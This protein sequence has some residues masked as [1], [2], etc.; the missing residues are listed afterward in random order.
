M[1]RMENEQ[2]FASLSMS[3]IDDGE[4]AI[5]YQD[6]YKL[7]TCRICPGFLFGPQTRKKDDSPRRFKYSRTL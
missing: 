5:D 6:F 1:V 4:E 7:I 2:K 3:D